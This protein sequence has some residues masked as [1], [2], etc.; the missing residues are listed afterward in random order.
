[1]VLFNSSIF[2]FEIR[3]FWAIIYQNVKHFSIR[4][5]LLSLLF[6]FVIAFVQ[7]FM[8]IF[9]LLD[10]IIYPNYR[11]TELKNPVFIISNPRSGTTYL[12][13]LICMDE[14]RF[15][16]FMLYHTFF[17]SILFYRFILLLKRIDSHLNW[18][19]R[20]FFEWIE[21]IVFK[22][23]QDIHP[24]GFEKSEEDEG[25]FVLQMMSPI[26][27]MFCPWFKDI[28]YPFVSDKLSAKKK[29]RM[30]AFYKNTLQRFSYAWGADK[31][32]LVKNVVSTGRIDMLMDAFPDA[33]IIY[34][35]RH[36]YKIV[37]SMTSMFTATWSIIAPNLPKNSPEF[38]TWGDMI[39]AFYRHFMNEIEHIDASKLYPCLYTELMSSPKALVLD[40]YKEFNFT[41]SPEFEQR[42]TQATNK[43]KKYKSKHHYSLEEYGY[44]KEEIYLPLKDVFERF[45]F[46]P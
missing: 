17:P 2:Y 25:I 40:I 44:T 21:K 3:V 46:K 5:L 27:G 22:G 36:P 23:W 26:I 12:H 38:R 1:M 19:M 45:D 16:Y 37:P 33:K 7:F 41:V 4:R 34:P 11:K 39:I 14:E 13:S 18:T 8:L 35:V 30:M 31:T 15:T 28:D 43:A 32:I 20:R 29:K 10:E 6:F 9:R 24:M 42:L